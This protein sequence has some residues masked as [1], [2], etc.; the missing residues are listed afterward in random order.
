MV[1]LSIAAVLMAIAVPSMREFIARQRVEGIAKELA[2]DLRYLRTQGI[3][4]R[5]PV[6]IIFGANDDATCYVLYGIGTGGA[7]CNCA[8][9]DGL[10][11][12]GDPA[13][14][15]APEEYKTVIIR[16]DSGIVLDAEPLRLTLD[17]FN[18]LP[19]GDQTIQ[20]SVRGVGMGG[21]VRVYT[22]EGD[23]IVPRTCSVAG[24]GGSL[25]PCPP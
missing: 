4:R 2:T 14:A 12:C 7:L 10:P 1:T 19:I 15:G 18:G 20:A 21:E 23:I 11:S 3:Q 16:R 17:G 9:T 6:R 13:A 25:Q 22:H 24:H 8:R 5:L